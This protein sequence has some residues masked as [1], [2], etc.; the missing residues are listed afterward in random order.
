MFPKPL[1]E[2]LP[3]IKSLN[4]PARCSENN[5][6][7]DTPLDDYSS[8]SDDGGELYGI[9]HNGHPPSSRRLS[10]CGRSGGRKLVVLTLT[11]VGI[12]LAAVLYIYQFI[13]PQ[14]YQE[15]KDLMQV[16]VVPMFALSTYTEGLS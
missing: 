13:I 8:A 2:D 14:T 12:F 5:R 15:E 6:D 9:S 11:G 7:E 10:H 16:S 1:D 4:A 3:E